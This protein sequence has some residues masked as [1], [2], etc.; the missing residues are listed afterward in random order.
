[1]F[2]WMRRN[3]GFPSDID[4]QNTMPQQG[5]IDMRPP[6]DTRPPVT[7]RVDNIVRDIVAGP[8]AP[9]RS[10][11][12]AAQQGSRALMQR[13]FITGSAPTVPHGEYPEST[14]F[15]G[16]MSD[17]IQGQAF[18]HERV[19]SD[20]EKLRNYRKSLDRKI[21]YLE[22]ERIWNEYGLPNEM[23]RLET[24]KMWQPRRRG[25]R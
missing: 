12:K 15:R 18:P 14:A 8:L 20:D 10:L 25:S 9:D 19:Y 17:L 23:N 22:N 24:T 2:D 3:L 7:P 16:Q 1:M 13:D 5:L 11:A 21:D 4:P 6:I